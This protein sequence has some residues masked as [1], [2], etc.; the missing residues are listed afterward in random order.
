MDFT[1]KFYPR[2][3]VCEWSSRDRGAGVRPAL[4]QAQKHRHS[5]ARVGAKPELVLS[6]G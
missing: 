6:L 4:G 5:S 2:Y 3:E 1:C